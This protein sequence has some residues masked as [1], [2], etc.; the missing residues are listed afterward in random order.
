M[1]VDRLDLVLNV[2][3]QDSLKAE[4]WE[5]RGNAVRVSVKHTTLIYTYIKKFFRHSDNKIELFWLII[6]R[7]PKFIQKIST[8]VICTKLSQ[9]T[10]N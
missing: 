5:N 3:H 10:S 6:D 2:Y 9:V 1:P 7:V 8:T 4:T